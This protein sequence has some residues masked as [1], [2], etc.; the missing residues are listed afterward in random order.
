MSI[1]MLGPR[2]IMCLESCIAIRIDPSVPTRTFLFLT[3]TQRHTFSLSV[4]VPFN[5]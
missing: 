4:G 1:Q 3:E 5:V 2:I